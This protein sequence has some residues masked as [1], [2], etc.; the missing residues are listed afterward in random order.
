MHLERF[1]AN[2]N[3]FVLRKRPVFSIHAKPT[4]KEKLF[5]ST[6]RQH[7]STMPKLTCSYKFH[8]Q[9]P[10]V[11]LQQN[12]PFSKLRSLASAVQL[13]FRTDSNPH[14]RYPDRLQYPAR[15]VTWWM[16]VISAETHVS[17]GDLNR[18]RSP[19]VRKPLVCFL[20][21]FAQR[22]KN[23][24]VSLSGTSEVLQTSFSTQQ[25]QHRTATIKTFSKRSFE[26]FQTSNQRTQTTN[27]HNPIKSFSASRLFPPPSAAV[28]PPC[29]G[30]LLPPQQFLPLRGFIR[31]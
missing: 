7:F 15:P 28:F 21:L 18:P 23:K 5:F 4:D 26:V 30:P 16:P 24:P 19:E 25:P 29:G 20:V 14:R 2:G 6:P 11:S 31:R 27:S 22:K 3:I 17:S 10:T 13:P 8:P 1:S 12:N 9:K